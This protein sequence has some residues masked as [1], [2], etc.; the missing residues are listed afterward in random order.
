M[1]D[2]IRYPWVVD[3]SKMTHATDFRYHYDGHAAMEDFL[4]GRA[5]AP[6]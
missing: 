4:H 6:S 3:G 1:L 5:L 2:Y